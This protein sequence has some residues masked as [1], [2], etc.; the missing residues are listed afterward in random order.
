MPCGWLEFGR[1]PF[2]T[3]G[4]KVSVCWFF[5]GARIASGL[6]LPGRSIE[7]ATPQGW[8]YEGSLSQQFHFI[9]SGVREGADG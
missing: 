4:Q 6:H 5:E 3:T 9:P 1:L 7:I 8:Q 2:S